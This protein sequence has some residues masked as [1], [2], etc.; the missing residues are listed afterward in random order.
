MRI[1]HPGRAE[2]RIRDLAV[3]TTVHVSDCN[4]LLETVDL[5]CSRGDRLLFGGLAI[6]IGVGEVVQ[7]NGPNGSGKTTLLR[8]LCGL[9]PATDGHIRWRG[10]PVPPGD[11][12]LRAEIQYIGHAGGVKLD[13]TPRE[14]LGV[15]IA[16]GA[17]PTGM[18]P[19]A[20]LARLG[21]GESQDAPLRTLSAGQR[22]RVALARLLA[23]R[24]TLWI[25]DEPFTALDRS[26]VAIVDSML[27]AHTEAGGAAVITSHHPVALGEV[28]PRLVHIDQAP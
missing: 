8:V 26:G 20:A 15:A 11:P 22:Q 18:G 28:A 10:V 17:G 3:Q 7:I 25:L 1:I 24:C 12:D 2:S 23:C 13:L 19:D 16:L 5:S 4:A 27:S 14:N 21:I 6:R 9:Q